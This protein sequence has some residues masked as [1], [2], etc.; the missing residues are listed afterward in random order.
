M[1]LSVDSDILIR[2]QV[3]GSLFAE[4]HVCCKRILI[5][6]FYVHFLTNTTGKDIN[7]LNFLGLG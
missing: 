6:V 2:R 7:P 4:L 1:I 5:P 3:W